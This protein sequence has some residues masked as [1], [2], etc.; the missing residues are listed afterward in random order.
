MEHVRYFRRYYRK[1][2]MYMQ[3]IEHDGTDARDEQ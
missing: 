3:T 2:N 1:A